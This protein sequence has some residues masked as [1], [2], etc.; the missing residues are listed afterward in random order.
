MSHRPRVRSPQRA[1]FYVATQHDDTSQFSAASARVG[2]S[3]NE[4]M[5]SNR[6]SNV[7]TS[8][9]SND[10]LKHTSVPLAQCLERWSYEPSAAHHDDPSQFSVAKVLANHLTNET[11]LSN[12]KSNAEIHKCFLSSVV[13]AVV[14]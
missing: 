4:W 1:T 14:L 12:R 11:I 10:R 5:R 3:T 9:R 6:K 2:L 8:V 7:A 13:R